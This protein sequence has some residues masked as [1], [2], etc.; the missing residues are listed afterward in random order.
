MVHA[1][2]LRRLHLLLVLQT[3]ESS[4]S[5]MHRSSSYNDK[6]DPSMTDAECAAGST[7]CPRAPSSNVAAASAKNSMSP[8]LVVT[9]SIHMQGLKEKDLS[10]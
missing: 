9:L 2:T 1:L 6:D 10:N 8:S 5:S 3:N 7:P 4:V